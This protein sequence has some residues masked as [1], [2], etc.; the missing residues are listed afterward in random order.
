MWKRANM[1][2]L[3]CVLGYT[4]SEKVPAVF[5]EDIQRALDNLSP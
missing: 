1:L 3:S 4:A 2:A 5:I